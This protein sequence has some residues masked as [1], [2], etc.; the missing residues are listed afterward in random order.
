MKN[1]LILISVL[2]AAGLVAALVAVFMMEDEPKTK[3]N[4]PGNRPSNP[5]Q[6]TSNPVAKLNA[7][8]I[9]ILHKGSSKA[10]MGMTRTRNEALEMAREVRELAV[11]EDADFAE[12]AKT[13][14]EGPSA[15]RGGA[16]GN[17]NPDSMAFEFS[18]ATLKL[19]VG[20][21]SEPVETQFGFHI[22]RR[23]ERD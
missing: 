18:E 19:R 23:N 10:P 5:M 21:I 7:S 22:I 14:S 16:L 20:E 8:H 6:G 2:M 15:K 17:F 11:A 3:N 13:H 9:L 1:P 4:Y 12:L